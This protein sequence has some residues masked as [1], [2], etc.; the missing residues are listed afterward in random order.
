MSPEQY[1]FGRRLRSIRNRLRLSQMQM[2]DVFNEQQVRISEWER[3]VGGPPARRLA[4][5]AKVLDVLEAIN[6]DDLIAAIEEEEALEAFAQSEEGSLYKRPLP[7]T[8]ES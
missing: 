3:G 6:P 7:A 2:A 4:D 1:V 5:F 8:E